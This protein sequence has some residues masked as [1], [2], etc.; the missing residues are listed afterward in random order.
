MSEE[1]LIKLGLK[2]LLDRSVP[3][4]LFDFDP[5]IS[6]DEK[7]VENALDAWKKEKEPFKYVFR[8]G[9]SFDRHGTTFWLYINGQIE[10]EPASDSNTIESESE[11]EIKVI[12]INITE[13]DGKTLNASE[14]ETKII[15]DKDMD[16]ELTAL[17]KKYAHG[18]NVLIDEANR[19]MGLSYVPES[20]FQQGGEIDKNAFA[21]FIEETK[22]ELVKFLKEKKSESFFENYIEEKLNTAHLLGYDEAEQKIKC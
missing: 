4:Q 17:S 9:Y 12:E 16:S 20:N 1:E 13:K 5:D 10:L 15:T 18:R 8:D 22:T 6:A 2:K 3:V 19:K 14:V 21:D 7:A 11:P